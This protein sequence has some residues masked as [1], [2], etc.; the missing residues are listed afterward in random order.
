[1]PL[2]TIIAG[3]MIAA[4][5]FYA[6]LGGADYGG[7][8]WD[9]FAFGP[10]AAAQRELIAKAIGPVWEA[11]HVWL[12]LVIV[13]LFSAFPAA[14]SAISIALHIP[15]TLL[16]IGIVLRGTAFVFRSYDSK[17][18][19]VQRRWSL[20]FSMAS[21]ITPVL[22]GVTLGAIASGT[23]R[24]EKGIVTSGFFN[25]WLDV[26]PFAVGVFAIVLFAFLAA[27]YL[28]L[29][30]EDR[31][32]QE[33]F[34]LRALLSGVA[35][36]IMALVVFLLAGTGAPVVRAGIS[37]TWWAAMLHILTAIFA[38]GAFYTLWTRKYK[39]ARI[40]AAAQAALILLGWAFSQ[41]PY[42]VVPDITIA[43]AA[44]PAISLQLLLGA[45]IGGALLL[46][47]SYYYLFR[48]FKSEKVFSGSTGRI[49]KNTE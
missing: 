48:V 6:L 21:I 7:G 10:R 18:D 44:A 46:F 13:V 5:I 36:G 14:F 3:S 31:G 19:R 33:D 22:L 24:V 35:V 12:I 8:V 29:E 28:T 11:N 15:L 1:M 16:L 25:A 39:W 27:V 43:S 30:T 38:L 32:L 49:G 20:V 41:F 4:L 37:Q 2:E 34:R 40:C 45:L 47:P 9:I 26:F 23:I 42:L 17:H